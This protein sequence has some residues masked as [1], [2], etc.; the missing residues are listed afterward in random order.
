MPSL[1]SNGY[2][3]RRTRTQDKAKRIKKKRQKA[4]KIYKLNDARAATT[5]RATETTVFISAT[6]VMATLS[7]EPSPLPNPPDKPPAAWTA[8][9]RKFAPQVL[10][11]PL[12]NGIWPP[13]ATA[14]FMPG[15]NWLS[16]S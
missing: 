5:P 3:N 11:I 14:L 13:S 7:L 1:Y 16:A 2:P 10:E 6:V 15:A 8:P 12:Y 9:L 4:S